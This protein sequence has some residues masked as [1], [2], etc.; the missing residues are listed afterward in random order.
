MLDSAFWASQ[1]VFL[2]GHTGFKGSWTAFWLGR[3]GADVSGYALAPETVPDLYSILHPG[4]GVRSTFGDILDIPS[5]TA[6]IAASNPTV[7]IHMAA[8]PLVRYSYREPARTFATNVTG[9]LNVLEAL[10][11]A[12]NL[13]AVL[14][15]TTDKVYRNDD[16]GHAFTEGDPLGGHDP[17]SS[18]KAACEEVVSCYRQSFYADMG[19]K[20]ATARAGNVV[21]GGDWSEDRLVPDL[22]RALQTGE[23][24]VLRNP[25]ST[26]PWQHVLDPVF[27]YLLYTEKLAGEEGANLPCALNFAPRPEQPL[28]V[29]AVTK[30]MAMRLHMAKGWRL[31]E[32][33]QPVEMKLLQL[34]ASLA[35]STLGW[36]PRMTSRQAMEWTADWYLAKHRGE[37]VRALTAR[38]LADYQEL[39]GL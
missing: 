5:L 24:V 31:A 29:E 35:A 16:S 21:G 11:R 1:R 9:T 8:Q 20:L 36:R 2:T 25:L 13:K 27:G 10:R 7:A 12:P 23:E 30:I 15:I 39:V 37:D 6:A 28:T 4:S 3:L 32:G 19:V 14:V 38:Q 18:S 22:W 26:R 17:Y 33:C 34:D